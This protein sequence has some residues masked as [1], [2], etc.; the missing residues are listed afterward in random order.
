[1]AT[2]WYVSIGKHRQASVLDV[3]LGVDMGLFWVSI[4]ES[5]ACIGTHTHTY[6][7]THIGTKAYVMLWYA[8]LA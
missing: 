7:Y 3:Y 4:W 5:H 1:M 2:I 8:M 6:M